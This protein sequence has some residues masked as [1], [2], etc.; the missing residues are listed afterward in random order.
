[1]SAIRDRRIAAEAVASH[2]LLPVALAVALLVASVLAAATIGPA[3]ISALDVWRSIAMHLGLPV[4]TTLSP[5]RDS[6]VW[7][8]RLPRIVTAGIVGAGL[9]LSGAVVQAVT[10]NPLADPFLLGLSSGAALGAVSMVMLA[11]PLLLTPGAFAGALAAL[12]L[13]LAFAQAIG[14]LTPS[15]AILS[16]IAVS[17]LAAALTSL[18][19]FWTATGDSYREILSWLMGSLAGAGWPAAGIAA[20]ALVLVA[21]L[22]FA[23]RRTMDAFAF[24]DVA[25]A[26]LGVDVTRSR[27]LLLG[28]TALL[29]GVLVSV[30]GAIGFVG[31]VVPHAARL[32]SG[33]G[34]PPDAAARRRG[35]GGVHDLDGHGG[36]QPV[37]AARAAGRHRD[38]DDRRPRLPRHPLALPAGDMS[39]AEGLAVSGGHRPHRLGDA[40]RRRRLRRA[41]RHDVRHRR[42]ERR[43]QDD[44]SP[45]HPRA[46]PAGPAATSAS[47]A[48]ISAPCRGRRA[49]A[50]SPSSSTPPRPSCPTRSATW[51]HSA[52]FP[53]QGRGWDWGRGWGWGP[54]ADDATICERALA[55]VGLLALADRPW[56]GLSGGEQQRVQIARALAQEPALLLLDEPTSHLDL[57]A[58]LATLAMLR[59][60]AAHGLTVVVAIHDLAL[61]AAWFDSVLVMRGGRKVACGPIGSTLT[62]DLVRA[63]YDVEVELIRDPRTGRLLVAPGLEPVA[64]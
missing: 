38:G 11:S 13:T 16:G 37:R 41:A 52:A 57:R 15:K 8:A 18:V 19:I 47:T 42:A 3:D 62:A 46:S 14:G 33:T 25:A 20:A 5:I 10:R 53:H 49:R 51:W 61:A 63:V 29:T 39:A 40:R 27:W 50:G 21:P 59:R 56:R 1:V 22:V 9:A 44:A 58:Q 55:D 6:I 45:L 17:T 28:G 26:T 60:Q 7:D 43:R 23:S 48:P 24:G 54:A 64:W 31:L 12:A 34:A 2:R 4:E 35:R 30:S 36:A 32:V